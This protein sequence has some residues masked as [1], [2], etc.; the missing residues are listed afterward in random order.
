MTFF[1]VDL[2]AKL[3]RGVY[4]RDPQ[5]GKIL[6]AG[7]KIQAKIRDPKSQLAI[8][9]AIIS[10]KLRDLAASVKLRDLAKSQ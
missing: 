5:Q 4:A 6:D 2:Y 10:V 8:F 1:I 9:F 3:P 7:A